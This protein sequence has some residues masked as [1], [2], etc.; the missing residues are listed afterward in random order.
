MQHIE[1]GL[2]G[3]IYII[4]HHTTKTFAYKKVEDVCQIVDRDLGFPENSTVWRINRVTSWPLSPHLAPIGP[5]FRKKA[6]KGP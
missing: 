4:P 6:P 5:Y 2:N 3:T 1:D